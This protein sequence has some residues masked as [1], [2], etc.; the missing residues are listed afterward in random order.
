M[1]FN[2]AQTVN[3]V[4]AGGLFSFLAFLAGAFFLGLATFGVALG[5]VPEVTAGLF[6]WAIAFVLE[7][8]GA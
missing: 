3:N 4:R 5:T 8:L 1:A 2:R 6:C 7:R